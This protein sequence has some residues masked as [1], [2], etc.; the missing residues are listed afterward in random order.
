M[1]DGQ[2]AAGQDSVAMVS[3]IQSGTMQ[4]DGG[5]GQFRGLI[6]VTV[7]QYGCADVLIVI[8]TS[9]TVVKVLRLVV[10]YIVGV[11]VQVAREVVRRADVPDDRASRLEGQNVSSS[12]DFRLLKG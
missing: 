5:G 6:E 9:L 2:Q 10:V 12:Q 8:S 3:M 11:G 7:G 4:V 1:T